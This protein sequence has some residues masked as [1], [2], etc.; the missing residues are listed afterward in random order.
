MGLH[1]TIPD[2]KTGAPACYWRV[3]GFMIELRAGACRVVLGGFHSKD[4]ADAGK[5]PVTHA[6]I[7]MPL[8]TDI[9]PLIADAEKFAITMPDFAGASPDAPEDQAQKHKGN[10]V[11]DNVKGRRNRRAKR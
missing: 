4:A 9:T 11:G 10:G 2:Q 1:K 8:R 6:S 7:D 5:D 3:V